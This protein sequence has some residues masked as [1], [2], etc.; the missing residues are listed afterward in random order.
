MSKIIA[1]ITLADRSKIT[2][3]SATSGNSAPK[4]TFVKD[5]RYITFNND[6]PILITAGTYSQLIDV[7][8]SDNNAFLTNVKVSLSSTGFIF[9]PA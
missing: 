8:S 1:F 5:T 7:K 9:E 6:S 4:L 2:A 3:A